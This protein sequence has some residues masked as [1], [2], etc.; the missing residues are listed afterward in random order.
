MAIYSVLWA[1]RERQV[2]GESDEMHAGKQ[3]RNTLCQTPISN[4]SSPTKKRSQH[5]QDLL[6]RW[7][8]LASFLVLAARILSV[9]MHFHG[10]FETSHRLTG[11]KLAQSQPRVLVV[12]AMG[13]T[14]TKPWGYRHGTRN[15]FAKKY[16]THGMPAF[17]KYNA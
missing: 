5:A 10:H 2:S 7:H 3:S 1:S 17:A 8:V 12:A 13:N 15:K 4:S 16:R 9:H 14:R 6:M 11:K